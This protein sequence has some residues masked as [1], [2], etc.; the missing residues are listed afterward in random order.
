MVPPPQRKW[1]RKTPLR[2]FLPWCLTPRLLGYGMVQCETGHLLGLYVD[3][4]KETHGVLSLY[5]DDSRMIAKYALYAMAGVDFWCTFETTMVPTYATGTI[6]HRR[7]G[8]L[9]GGSSSGCTRATSSSRIPSGSPPASQPSASPSTTESKCTRDS[10]L[11]CACFPRVVHSCT[12]TLTP[13]AVTLGA[14]RTAMSPVFSPHMPS[15]VAWC[16]PSC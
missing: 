16:S 5:F 6:V 11:G 12:R 3:Y 15:G 9:L 10:A 14:W 7:G 2:G 8:G 1:P 4:I 13:T